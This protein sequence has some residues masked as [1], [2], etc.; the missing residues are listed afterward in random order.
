MLLFSGDL[1]QISPLSN[2]NIIK[3]AC[4]HPRFYHSSLYKLRDYSWYLVFS[5]VGVPAPSCR[6]LGCPH[7]CAQPLGNCLCALKLSPLIFLDKQYVNQLVHA[8]KCFNRFLSSGFCKN[9]N[10]L[11]DQWFCIFIFDFVPE[12]N[13]EIVHMGDCIWMLFSKL[14]GS[15]YKQLCKALLSW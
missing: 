11:A 15:L 14:F 13:R 6:F 5:H 4:Q 3:E 8:M 12:I 2:P 1:A 7:S 10:T 9:C